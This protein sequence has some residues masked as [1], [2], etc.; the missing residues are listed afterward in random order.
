MK[1]QKS[2]EIK[3]VADLPW[4][5]SPNF[6]IDEKIENKKYN[7]IEEKFK[8]IEVMSKLETLDLY[9]SE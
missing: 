5:E 4:T 2:E 6:L 8:M 1:N 7:I 3:K 9:E